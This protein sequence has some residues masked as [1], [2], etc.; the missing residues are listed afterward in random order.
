MVISTS[1]ERGCSLK[2]HPV[3]VF[4]SDDTMTGRVAHRA[5]GLID[6]LPPS[7]VGALERFEILVSAESCEAH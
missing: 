6:A 4:T 2:D 5:R 1:P 7:M 3:I